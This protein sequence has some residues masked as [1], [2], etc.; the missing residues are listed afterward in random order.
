MARWSVVRSSLFFL[1][2]SLSLFVDS[3]SDEIICPLLVSI[4]QIICREAQSYKDTGKRTFYKCRVKVV[5]LATTAIS[6]RTFSR[7]KV[8]PFATWEPS[9]RW[10]APLLLAVARN[11]PRVDGFYNF[12]HERSG[13]NSRFSCLN[14]LSC[15]ILFFF[16]FV[17][18]SLLNFQK[19]DIFNA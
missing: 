11:D 2:L 7:R 19:K 8:V 9:L 14:V 16:F 3:L 12:T 13:E 1:S 15:W 6:K 4:R 10:F 17:V 18:C 5:P